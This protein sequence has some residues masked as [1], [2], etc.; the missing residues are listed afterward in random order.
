LKVVPALSLFPTMDFMMKTSFLQGQSSVEN[1]PWKLEN[2]FDIKHI[3]QL[4]H[5]EE[6]L[7]LN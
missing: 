3:L 7:M 2:N 1:D 4:V 6:L 5:P